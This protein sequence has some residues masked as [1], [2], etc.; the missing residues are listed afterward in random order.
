MLIDFWATWCAPCI[1]ELPHVREAFKEFGGDGDFVVISVSLDKT[2]KPVASF[3]K[4]EKLTWPQIVAGPAEQNPIAKQYNVE[5][6][7]ATFL[8]DADGKVVAKDLRGKHLR[9]KVRSHVEKTRLA[10]AKA[11]KPGVQAAKAAE[12]DEQ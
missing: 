4:K 5:G 9:E 10:R 7:P 8:I 11:R 3:V 6:I 12:T 1:A 2:D